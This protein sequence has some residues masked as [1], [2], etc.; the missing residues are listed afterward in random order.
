MQTLYQEWGGVFSK[1][2]IGS[3]KVF[4]IQ[5]TALFQLQK[6]TLRTF[7]AEPHGS[8]MYEIPRCVVLQLL[9]SMFTP[10]LAQTLTACPLGLGLTQQLLPAAPLQTGGVTQLHNSG[11]TATLMVH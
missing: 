4:G 7:S 2:R 9:P 3:K 5:R 11:G 1:L 6:S 8:G 10:E